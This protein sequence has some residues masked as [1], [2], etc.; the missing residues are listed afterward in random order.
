MNANRNT[1]NF[2]NNQ[3]NRNPT[4]F[5]GQNN[6]RKKNRPIRNTRRIRGNRPFRNNRNINNNIN[7]IIK[8]RNGNRR[9]M[10]K[11]N[12]IN[13]KTN[14]IEKQVNELTDKIDRLALKK[15]TNYY[16]NGN[17]RKE[18]RCDKLYSALQMSRYANPYSFFEPTNK[19]IPMKVYSKHSIHVDHDY[20]S[21]LWF[22]YTF[23]GQSKQL[24]VNAGTQEDP[25]YINIP[26]DCCCS[27]FQLSWNENGGISYSNSSLLFS[28]SNDI[29]G[30]YRLVC[31]TLKIMN[32]TPILYKGG[33]ASVYKLT[34]NDGYPIL[35]NKGRFLQT[36]NAMPEFL[37]NSFN[38]WLETKRNNFDNNTIK[39][40]FSLADDMYIDEYNVKEGN[41]IFQ[42]SE[43]YLG[44]NYEIWGAES[45]APFLAPMPANTA[46]STEAEFNPTGQNIKYLI[47]F[48]AP[49]DSQ[50]LIVELCQI[51]E[52]IPKE[53]SNYA[54]LALQQNY[55]ATK[56]VIELAK[57]SF[58]IHK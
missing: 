49:V 3:N 50:D 57:N 52:V 37:V 8:R 44:R 51:F 22:P 56:D 1:R 35:T 41:N 27:C 9:P 29:F 7:N 18:I 23:P 19:I 33:T 47:N 20:F 42:S 30:N 34:N 32:N 46:R 39:M 45:T 5:R 28:N 55:I 13:I 16:V 43:E 17:V 36:Y 6:R 14:N 31:S 24:K 58:P 48:D 11:I 25:N 10:R 4:R 21:L 53:D 15:P 54:N 2:R 40:V 12:K 26:T 38:R